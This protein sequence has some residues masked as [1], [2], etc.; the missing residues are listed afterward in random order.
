LEKDELYTGK[1]VKRKVA[2]EANK[3]GDETEGK[4]LMGSKT[5]AP[6]EETGQIPVQG[7]QETLKL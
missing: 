2:C 5:K 1:H 3:K 4:I 7:Q 6:A